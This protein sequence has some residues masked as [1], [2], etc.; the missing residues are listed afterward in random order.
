M[1][2]ITLA[3]APQ[4]VSQGT[5]VGPV[6]SPFSPTTYKS[7][8]DT[9]NDLLAQAL[10]TRTPDVLS[11]LAK[12]ATS[13][14]LGWQKT[15]NEDKADAARSSATEKFGNLISALSGQK[16]AEAAAPVP[17]TYVPTAPMSA[18]PV[19][20]PG[21]IQA[22]PLGA[23]GA[24]A[25]PTAAPVSGSQPSGYGTSASAL[26]PQPSG[27]VLAVDNLIGGVGQQAMA[28]GVGSDIVLPPEADAVWQRM[29]KQESGGKQ[30]GPD[31]KPL[32]SSAGAV[33]I[34]QVMPG[35]AQ[36]AAR[37]AGLPWDENRYRTDPDYNLAL[38][39][40]YYANMVQKYGDPI[41]AAG[42]YNVGPGGMDQ[43]LAGKRGLPQETQNYMQV[44]SGGATQ[45]PQPASM[46]AG[47]RPIGS[48]Q[49]Q[50]TVAGLKL[51]DA[52]ALLQFISDP[53][54]DEGQKGVA[55]FLLTQMFKQNA[56]T[57][58][59]KLNDTT[60][61]DPRTGKTQT[62]GGGAGAA[63]AGNAGD[64]QAINY[65]VAQ[66]KITKEQGA[67]WLAAK[68]A[69]GPNGQVDYITPD[70]LANGQSVGGAPVQA[71]G[72]AAPI[73][74]PNNAL[75]PGQ[76]GAQQVAATQQ[77][78]QGQPGVTTVRPPQAG[79]MNKEQSDAALYADR[80]RDSDSVLDQVGSVGQDKTQQIL[81]DIPLVG[82]YLVSSD[83]QR[84]D[85]AQRN[86]I[87]ASLRRESGAAISPS[88]FAS[89]NA[90]YFPQ[91]GDGSEVLAQKKQNRLRQIEGLARAAGPTYK[92]TDT[93][94]SGT[95][96]A[97]NYKS[98]YGLE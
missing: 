19:K 59:Q 37:M 29:V 86:F 50:Q 22:Q 51:P 52:G 63:F 92:P 83:K 46:Q 67:Q 87:N 9:Y 16:T 49:P 5:P 62:V 65:L 85:Q 39:K 34:A 54:A 13:G 84:L 31:G 71:S 97:A 56:P 43:Y 20:S 89:A 60:L 78:T 95:P 10:A 38:G 76:G 15:K 12:L 1:A 58:L 82:N 91:P 48:Q 42:A 21:T 81:G 33:G 44:V 55:S 32:T 23:P 14:F 64:V 25:A 94:S 93:P 77:V 66:N 70:A 53:W 24:P 96:A 41:K 69:V 7:R 8:E 2:G 35:T 57:E 79:S 61:F 11:G 3:P 6:V 88:E 45:A 98:K 68:Q 74:T 47:Y 90:Q 28:G 36:E 4:T 30:F 27:A 75:L 40:A 26:P 73:G 72:A 80:M 18:T 17:S